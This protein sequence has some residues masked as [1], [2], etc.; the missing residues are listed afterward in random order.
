VD[1][2]AMRIVPTDVANCI[3][4]EPHV[5]SDQ[6]GFFLETYNRRRYFDAGLHVDFVQDNHSCSQRDTLRGLHYQVDQPQGKLVTVIRGAILDVAVDLRRSSATYGKWISCTLSADNHHQ[7][8]VPPGCAH[9]FYA[10]ED[11]TE[12]LY[13]CT[14]YYSPAGE[15]TI[16][17]DDET[18]AIDWPSNSPILSAKDSQGLSFAAAPHCD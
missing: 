17:W 3:L 7:L 5:Y 2:K 18:L 16:R 9:G 8:Y 14:D 11:Q 1:S 15:R 10:L 6:R 12:V 13:K 4:F